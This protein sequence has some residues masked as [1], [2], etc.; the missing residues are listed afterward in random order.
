MHEISPDY[1]RE[2]N[3]SK[4]VLNERRNMG[5]L[6]DGY[7]AEIIISGYFVLFFRLFALDLR[8]IS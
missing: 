3:V 5:C 8:S 6:P 2:R 4:K 1:K 7:F